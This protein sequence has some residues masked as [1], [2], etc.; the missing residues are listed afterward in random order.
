MNSSRINCTSCGNEINVTVFEGMTSVYC[1][2][3]R[4]RIALGQGSDGQP[5][6]R[7]A[8][9][10]VPKTDSIKKRSAG[11]EGHEPEKNKRPN[12]LGSDP[13]IRFEKN[14]T[15]ISERNAELRDST[16][17]RVFTGWLPQGFKGSAKH[18][19]AGNDPDTPLIL[20]SFAKNGAGQ[21]MFC[22]GRKNYRINKLDPAS[23][24]AFKGFD[25]YLDE[26]AAAILGTNRIR[27]IK[28]VPALKE[29][30]AEMQ[31]YLA[32]RRAGIEAMSRGQGMQY[33]VQGQYGANAGKLYEADTARGKRYLLL[34]VSMLADEYCSY[35]PLLLS[36]QQRSAQMMSRMGMGF[37]IPMQQAAP[38]I[39]TDPN[40]PFGCHAARGVTSAEIVWNIYSLGCFMS[41]L[42][43]TRNELRDFYRFINSLHLDSSFAQM[44]EQLSQQIAYNI[45]L[46]QQQA[47]Q[48]MGQ[49][50]SDQQR[51]HDRQRDI[52]NSLNEHRDRVSQEMYAA[53]NADFD[54]RSRLQHESMMGVNSYDRTDGRRVEADVSVDRVFQHINDPDRL[55]SAGMTAD[56]PFDWTELEKLK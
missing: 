10:T 11:A 34:N 13:F 41:D 47:Q 43:P 12:D 2:G 23:Q 17:R 6:T 4:K 44:M 35:S 8:R 7:E 25:D 27:V 49:M 30:T 5:K 26:N 56:V 1:P 19:P 51:S 22:R 15:V 42:L 39:D 55:A 52:M 31:R 32:E 54:H 16:G 38:F 14:E 33:V 45:M 36:S 24:G 50:I 40:T 3:C 18:E 21:E 53:R 20:W 48:I 28:R 9:N 46:D 37:G 29:T